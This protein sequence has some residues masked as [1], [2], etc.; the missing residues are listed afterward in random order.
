MHKT[1]QHHEQRDVLRSFSVASY[2]R[3]RSMRA[4][5]VPFL[6]SVHWIS[7]IRNWLREH[8]CNAH[9]I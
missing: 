7:R 6:K 1:E 3:V 2:L 8:A 4:G 9:A 5:I